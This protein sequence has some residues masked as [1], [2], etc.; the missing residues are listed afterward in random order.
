MATGTSG[1]SHI[2]SWTAKQYTAH[3]VIM[4]PLDLLVTIAINVAMAAMIGVLRD[5]I[6]V[7]MMD[8]VNVDPMAL[9]D[10]MIVLRVVL[11]MI[12]TAI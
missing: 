12:I 5:V 6:K 7:A 10:V 3:Q 4:L 11:T 2:I 8:I 9:A 1:R